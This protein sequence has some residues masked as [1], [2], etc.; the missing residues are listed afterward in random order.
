MGV[1]GGPRWLG[2][3]RCGLSPAAGPRLVPGGIGP[4][5][6]R[7]GTGVGT[8]SHRPRPLSLPSP[9]KGFLERF[10][11]PARR[12][13]NSC[14]GEGA[15]GSPVRAGFGPR[16]RGGAGEGARELPGERSRSRPVPF[17]RRS[18]EHPRP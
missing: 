7:V 15:R 14:P 6:H 18:G 12:S 17:A 3:E 1:R 11:S 5:R 9:I 8:G 13:G 16:V 10:S 4:S 2:G